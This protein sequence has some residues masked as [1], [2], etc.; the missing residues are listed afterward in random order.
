MSDECNIF[1]FHKSSLNFKYNTK[2]GEC[3][4]SIKEKI[5]QELNE[6]KEE[7]LFKL[8]HYLAYLKSNNIDEKEIAM[9]FKEFSNEDIELAE[10]GIDDYSSM[11]LKEDYE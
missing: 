7:Q 6:L 10:E 9:L 5:I 4:I 11:L 2:T 3:M 8:E 1:V